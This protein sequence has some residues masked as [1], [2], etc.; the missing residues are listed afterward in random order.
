MCYVYM[1]CKAYIMEGKGKRK[2]QNIDSLNIKRILK[3][4]MGPMDTDK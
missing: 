4:F 2:Q 1:S 3:Y